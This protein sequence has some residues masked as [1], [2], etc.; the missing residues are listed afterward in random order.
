MTREVSHR[1]TINVNNI[2][3]ENAFLCSWRHEFWQKLIKRR[4]PCQE[5]SHIFRFAL[6]RDFSWLFKELKFT[7]TISEFRVGLK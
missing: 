4:R 2:N 3:S 6:K 5:V 7:S 1:E